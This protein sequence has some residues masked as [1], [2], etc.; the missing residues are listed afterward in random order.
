[1]KKVFRH[2]ER[3][4]VVSYPNDIYNETYWSKYGG[5]GQLTQ[6]GMKRHNHFGKFLRDRYANFLNKYYNRNEVF[7]RSTDYDRTLMSAY[8]LLSG[9]YEPQDYQKWSD[10]VGSL[11]QPIAVHTTDALD[12]KI[13]YTNSCPRKDKL[14]NQVKNTAEYK[15]ATADY[16]DILDVVDKFSGFKNMTINEIWKIADTVFVEKDNNLTLPDWVQSNLD[17]IE[18]TRDLG[19]YFDYYNEELAK[20]E[21]GN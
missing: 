11:W 15:K 7:V 18:S 9:L 10:N 6:A 20:I 14:T 12:D 13:F 21:A 17:R 5:F 2:G 16:Q 4:P 1:L 19:F 8:S 3:T